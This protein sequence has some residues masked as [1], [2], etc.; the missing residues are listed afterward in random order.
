MLLEFR[1]SEDGTA[2][3]F[4]K[5]LSSR[6]DIPFL[7]IDVLSGIEANDSMRKSRLV[8][9]LVDGS[10]SPFDQLRENYR[11]ECST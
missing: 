6:L 3:I 9:R 4:Q 1:F 10:G 8:E 11:L 2:D 7:V 5:K